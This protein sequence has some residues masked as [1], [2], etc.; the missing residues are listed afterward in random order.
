MSREEIEKNKINWRPWEH[1]EFKQSTPELM[2]KE[3]RIEYLKKESEGKEEME[4]MIKLGL[5]PSDEI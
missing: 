1:R 5:I 3:A 4:E 2:E